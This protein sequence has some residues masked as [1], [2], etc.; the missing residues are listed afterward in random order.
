[1]TLLY[2]QSLPSRDL[3]RAKTNAKSVCQAL[4]AGERCIRRAVCETRQGVDLC[5]RHDR[6]LA[7]LGRLEVAS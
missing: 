5:M 2:E 7:Q 3:Q 4:T 1:M 6:E